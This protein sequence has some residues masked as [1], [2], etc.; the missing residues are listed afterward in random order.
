MV[1]HRKC[2]LLLCCYQHAVNGKLCPSDYTMLSTMSCNL[3]QPACGV[4]RKTLLEAN[5]L[6]MT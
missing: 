3:L 1:V 5:Q 6:Q 2:R 4:A